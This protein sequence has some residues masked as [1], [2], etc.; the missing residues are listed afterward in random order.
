MKKIFYSFIVV[1]ALS[2][3]GCSGDNDPNDG[4]FFSDSDRG[5]VT[6]DLGTEDAPLPNFAYGIAGCELSNQIVIPLTIDAPTNK[7]GLTIDYTITD[8]EGTSEGVISHLGY[9]VFPAGSLNGTITIDFP[10]TVTS[11]IGFTITL[12]DPSR[13]NISLGHPDDSTDP[14][15]FVVRINTGNRDSL[16][17]IAEDNI[18][19][20]DNEDEFSYTIS[21]GPAA[22]EIL[23]SDLSQTFTPGTTSQTRVFIEPDGTLSGPDFLENYLYV[24]E[25][26]GDTY[27]GDIS[28]TYDACEGTIN[29][30]YTLRFG[31]TGAAPQNIVLTRTYPE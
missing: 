6:F 24:N 31:T 16:L 26:V 23:I 30:S 10:E 27:V 14:L 4:K 19:A 17:G 13:D 29:L 28:G 5:W 12:T 11:S 22:N 15:T 2:L 20:G 21:Q 1:A 18:V 7:N 8:F 9:A 25:N 3:V